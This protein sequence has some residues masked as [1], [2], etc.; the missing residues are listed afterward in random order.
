MYLDGYT[1]FCRIRIKRENCYNSF[2]SHDEPIE[3]KENLGLNEW[4]SSM[5][6]D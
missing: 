1:G 2:D 6:V 5:F 4:N 3:N